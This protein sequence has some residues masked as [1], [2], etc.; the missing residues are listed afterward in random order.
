VSSRKSG[1]SNQRGV[2]INTA[3]IA[4]LEGQ[5][6]TGGLFGSGMTLTIARDLA[7]RGIRV[8]AIAPGPVL[9]RV[10]LGGQDRRG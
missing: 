3:S 7:E 6:G 10:P 4:G 8:M 5:P 2:I 9:H 1:A